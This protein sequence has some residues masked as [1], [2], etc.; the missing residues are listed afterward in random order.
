LRGAWELDQP[1][2]APT[3]SSLPDNGAMQAARIL[4][5]LAES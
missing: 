2:N 1:L 4:I 5:R 3:C